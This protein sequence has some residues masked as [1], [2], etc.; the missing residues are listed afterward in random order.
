MIALVMKENR[1]RVIIFKGK[2][3]MLKIGL[4]IRN[5]T[6][7]AIPAKINPPGPPLI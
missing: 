2:V 1:P 6:D 7:K 3:M 5:N 4:T